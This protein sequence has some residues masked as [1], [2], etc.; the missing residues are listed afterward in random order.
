MYLTYRLEVI[1]FLINF[2][3][4]SIDNFEIKGLKFF[5]FFHS[6]D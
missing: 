5:T 4:K 3:L 6:I 2:N 1:R